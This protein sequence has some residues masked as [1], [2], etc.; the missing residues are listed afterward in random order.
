MTGVKGR[1]GPP[2]H[3][4]GLKHGAYSKALVVPAG[5]EWV[6]SMIRAHHKALIEDLGGEEITE[7]QRGL[8]RVAMVA[9]KRAFL[10]EAELVEGG[11]LQP[12][13]NTRDLLGRQVPLFKLYVDTLKILGIERRA[14][15]PNDLDAVLRADVAKRRR[16]ALESE[17]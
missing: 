7:A 9:L 15:D 10:V 3:V 5:R 13:G 14:V 6:G 12:D 16:A 11:M 8:L 17:P 4:H 1:S 2:G